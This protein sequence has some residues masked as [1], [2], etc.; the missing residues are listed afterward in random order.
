[1]RPEN[2]SGSLDLESGG[3]RF[4][5]Q[6]PEAHF[7]IISGSLFRKFWDVLGCVWKWFGDVFGWVWVVFFSRD[8]KRIPTNAVLDTDL[9][10]AAHAA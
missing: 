10:N 6:L 7:G 1:M 4:D 3:R 5:S 2:P 8:R 9:D